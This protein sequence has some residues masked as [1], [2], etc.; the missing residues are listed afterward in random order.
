MCQEGRGDGDAFL[1]VSL[2]RGTATWS[3]GTIAWLVAGQAVYLK[4]L[5]SFWVM[6]LA[7]A[8]LCCWL[9]VAFVVF[10]FIVHPTTYSLLSTDVVFVRPTP[11]SGFLDVAVSDIIP[12]SNLT[13]WT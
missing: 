10:L 4:A 11:L 2:C 3:K 6:S 1:T 7:V 12:I 9:P 5:F 8:L 13:T